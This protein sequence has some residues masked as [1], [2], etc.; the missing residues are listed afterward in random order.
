MKTKRFSFSASTACRTDETF[1]NVIYM[2][3]DHIEKKPWANLI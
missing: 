3:K 1:I 2:N